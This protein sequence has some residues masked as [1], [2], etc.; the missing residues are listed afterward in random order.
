M[1]FGLL[2]DHDVIDHDAGNL[3]FARVQGAALGNAFDLN[4]DDATRVVRGTGDRDG[5]QGQRFL[6]HRHVAIGVGGGAAQEGN[7]D[8]IGLVKEVFLA[9]D[10]HQLDDVFLGRAVDLATAITRI[11]KGAQTN[12]GHLPR[13]ARRDVTE[14]MGNHTLRQVVGF[15]L[16]LDRQFLQLGCQ[17]PV[18]ADDAFHQAFMAQMIEAAIL[19]V[20]LPGCIEQG[21]VTRRTGRRFRVIAQKTLFQGDGDVFGKTDADKTTGRQGVAIL[22]VAD[23]FGGADNLVSTGRFFIVCG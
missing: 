6:F 14:Q 12:A 21:Q 15:D 23:R 4:D 2:G 11:D 19:A 18:A 1:V 17:P 16:A 9:A 20:A 22:D 5:F 13:F 8:R 7:M 10:L 3:D